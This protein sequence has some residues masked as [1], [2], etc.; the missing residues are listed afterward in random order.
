MKISK[1]APPQCPLGRNGK[2]GTERLSQI[3]QLCQ[4]LNCCNYSNRV[5]FF[6]SHQQMDVS[7]ICL[8]TLVLD[9]TQCAI[10]SG[11]RKY[12]RKFEIVAWTGI[13][14]RHSSERT[15]SNSLDGPFTLFANFDKPLPRA[16]ITTTEPN[17][18]HR[19]D[20]DVPISIDNRHSN[21]QKIWQR[22][23]GNDRQMSS[24]SV[25]QSAGF[26]F[27]SNHTRYPLSDTRTVVLLLTVSIC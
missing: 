19:L 25:S 24:Q 4:S 26:D 27:G 20:A 5:P 23:D 21:W 15:S 7:L 12:F 6:V 9:V 17:N 16:L 1:G 10:S 18:E 2:S 11:P 3:F 14:S 22:L 8:R 13:L